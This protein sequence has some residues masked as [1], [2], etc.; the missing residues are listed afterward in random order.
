[1]YKMAA[2]VLLGGMT[3]HH[4]MMMCSNRTTS[5]FNKMISSPVL[6]N[7]FHSR[8]DPY[9]PS[10]N[11]AEA[12]VVTYEIEYFRYKLFTP[13]LQIFRLFHTVCTVYLSL[14]LS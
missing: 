5:L 2:I 8:A 1:M 4:K 11:P 9:I 7:L 6:C 10:S 13:K 14:Y 3:H 12:F